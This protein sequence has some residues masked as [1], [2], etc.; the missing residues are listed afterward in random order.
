[1]SVEGVGRYEPWLLFF[2]AL[3]TSGT[4]SHEMQAWAAEAKSIALPIAATMLAMRCVRFMAALPG[5]CV[6]ISHCYR[7]A[8]D[9]ALS[10]AIHAA[11]DRTLRMADQ[12]PFSSVPNL[13]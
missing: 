8:Q 1:M 10:P 5:N 13:P 2:E 12:R 6:V 9:P 11:K 3:S 7:R 4:Y